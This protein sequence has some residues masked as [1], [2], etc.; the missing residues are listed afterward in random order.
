MSSAASALASPLVN[1]IAS[2]CGPGT[3][4]AKAFNQAHLWLQDTDKK[5][6][7]PFTAAISFGELWASAA[8]LAIC[9]LRSTGLTDSSKHIL[10]ESSSR[11][12][13]T[14]YKACPLVH[15]SIAPTICPERFAGCTNI[16]DGLTFC[17][18]DR[19]DS[20]RTS[21]SRDTLVKTGSPLASNLSTF[22]RVLSGTSDED[23]AI[24]PMAAS[25]PWH[26]WT[27]SC[28]ETCSLGFAVHV[29]LCHFVDLLCLLL[30]AVRV[31]FGEHSWNLC[32][33]R[34]NCSELVSLLLPSCGQLSQTPYTW[35][36][37][38]KHAHKKL[39]EL[40]SSATRA[41][42]FSYRSLMTATEG[43]LDDS[44]WGLARWQPLRA[45]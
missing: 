16:S 26:S 28:L 2:A 23:P 40:A 21:V 34:W 3:L 4:D 10:S 32:Y 27:V 45:C 20:C 6:S 41:C 18:Q 14:S 7:L 29:A 17:T 30:V 25:F 5:C 36:L 39:Q 11:R 15:T 44:H 42:K 9:W 35:R 24:A 31:A 43:L 33:T 8:F 38:K 1:C 37:C 13:P 19:P 12:T 22:N